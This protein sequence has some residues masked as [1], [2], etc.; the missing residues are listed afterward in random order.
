MLNRSEV[1]FRGDP[2][3]R[4]RVRLPRLNPIASL[5]TIAMV[6]LFAS[7]AEAHHMTGGR[8][9]ATE[10]EGLIS[11]LAHPV[12]GLDHLLALVAIGILCAGLARGRFLAA[13]FALSGLIGTGIHL[14]RLTIPGGE[15]IVALTVVVFGI[16]VIGQK[17][18]AAGAAPM[19]AWLVP[20]I[21]A[22]GVF[23]GYAYGESIVGA[24]RGPLV[25]YLVGLTMI[26]LA[27]LL[28][29]RYLTRLVMTRTQSTGGRLPAFVGGTLSLAGVALVVF[30]LRR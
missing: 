20:L 16:L 9:P 21:A 3:G 1:A 22:G 29:V 5:G 11:G 10:L 18:R 24:Q 14:M 27:T 25:A 23:H 19:P 13:I 7:P 12:I 4:G 6:L 26:Q 28:F 2:I 15:L 17:M 8:L 30:V